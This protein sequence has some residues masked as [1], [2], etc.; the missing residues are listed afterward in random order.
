VAHPSH[1]E[2]VEWDEGNEDELRR[3]GISVAEAGEVLDAPLAWARNKRHRPGDYKVMGRTAG[4]RAVS[5]VVRY[6][7]ARRAVRPI[8]GWDATTGELSRYF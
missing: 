8:T 1:A 2:Y 3:H 5:L 4:G 7:E 6:D